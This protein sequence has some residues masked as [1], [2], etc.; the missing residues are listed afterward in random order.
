MSSSDLNDQ[1]Q[2]TAHQNGISK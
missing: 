2:I 1:N